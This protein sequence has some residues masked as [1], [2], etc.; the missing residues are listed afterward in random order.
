MKL[1]K[2]EEEL[3]QHIWRLENAFMK[4]ILE[5]YEEPKPAT[6]TIATL[7]KRIRD[8]GFI[9]YKTFGKSRKYYPLVSKSDYFGKHFRGLLQNFFGNSASRFASF[10]TQSTDLT[11]DELEALR[12]V[13]DEEIKKK[14]E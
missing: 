1:S 2:T 13:I 7:L 5:A 4:D 6:T 8:K 9:D 3:M 14:D 12:A 11:K 10:F